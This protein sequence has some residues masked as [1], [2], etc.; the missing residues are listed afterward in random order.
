MARQLYTSFIK[1]GVISRNVEIVRPDVMIGVR[2]LIPP[3][4]CDYVIRLIQQS[5]DKRSLLTHVH[6]RHRE[7]EEEEEEHK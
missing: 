1:Q 7:E 4:V 5:Q 2:T 3:L 6:C